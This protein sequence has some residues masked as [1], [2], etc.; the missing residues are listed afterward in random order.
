MSK[1]PT[2]LNASIWA[3]G[4]ARL[5]SSL[6]TTRTSS[7][8]SSRPTPHPA[9]QHNSAPT[10]LTPAQ[11]FHRFEQACQRLRWKFIDLQ[12]SYHRATHPE[13]F[14]FT[15]ADAERNFK[16]DFHEF[17]VWIEQAIVLL[18]LIFGVSIARGTTF[19]GV[20]HAYHHNVLR[21][22]EDETCPVYKAL[23]RGEVNQ[24][25][26]KAKELRNRWKDASEGKETPPLKMYDLTW[27][28]GQILGGLE[29]G[30]GIAVQRVEMEQGQGQWDD[31]DEHMG[32]G[33]EGGD[34]EW[35]WMVEPMDW[36]AA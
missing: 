17:Y 31:G 29:V 24:A 20:G 7:Q 16:V 19:A 28:V 9:P 3:N 1:T 33:A 23:G 18:L 14:A 6:P 5:N 22:L 13:E 4:R 36:E 26:W 25:L 12:N 8:S 11:A 34:N 21:A 27:L 2:G 15:V 10:R 30:Y 35:E 32:V